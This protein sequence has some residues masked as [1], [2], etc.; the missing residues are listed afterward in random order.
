[1]KR[2]STIVAYTRNRERDLYISI[3]IPR[4]FFSSKAKG[5]YPRPVEGGLR[6]ERVSL[7]TPSCGAS[8]ESRK[9]QVLKKPKRTCK[10][11][12]SARAGA[13]RGSP[14][15]STDRIIPL[16]FERG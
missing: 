7:V 2:G 15:L 5:L 14:G 1:M 16:V 3:A 12:S 11:V 10:S 6:N 4:P 9:T 8:S 13:S